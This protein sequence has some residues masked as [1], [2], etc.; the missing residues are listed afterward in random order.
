MGTNTVDQ[1]WRVMSVVGPTV[2][3]QS[4]GTPTLTPQKVGAGFM[5]RKWNRA[6][7]AE[8]PFLL[9][10]ENAEAKTNAEAMQKRFPVGS[11]ATYKEAAQT[12]KVS[13]EGY[14]M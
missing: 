4:I 7:D 5:S 2:N 12:F 3:L 1:K 8:Q 13:I 9:R 6:P 10:A 14:N 11:N